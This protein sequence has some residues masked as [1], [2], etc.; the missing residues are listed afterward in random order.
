[1]E[2][3]VGIQGDGFVL[4]ASDS[5][6][7]RSIVRMKEDYDKMT[8]LSSKLLM[9]VSGESGDTTQFAEYIEKNVQLYKM[10]N[11]Y[12]LTPHAA[13]NFTRRTLAEYL[14]SSTPFMVNLLI[15][16]YGDQG[17]ELYHMDYLAAM[18]KVPFGA[19]GYG[20]FFALSVMDRFYKPN[21]N[22]EEAMDLLKKVISEVQ[23]RFIVSLPN[24]AVR[25]VDKDGI[26]D[27]SVP[28]VQ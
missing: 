22:R 23:K 24:F 5:S 18:A 2:F 14:R 28:A 21:I 16:G 10:R 11:G 15:A 7:G 9:L 4:V 19:H 17:P 6:S 12:E 8:Q 1:M 20:S 27:I 13:S 25:V 3:M 26:H